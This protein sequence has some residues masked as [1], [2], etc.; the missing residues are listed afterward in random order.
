MSDPTPQLL[1]LLEQGLTP[2][3][4]A[5]STQMSLET[6]ESILG[7]IERKKEQEVKKEFQEMQGL[8]TN[9]IKK[10]LQYGE[11]E[12]AMIRAAELVLDVNMGVKDKQKQTN[13]NIFVLLNERLGAVKQKRRE[14]DD[15]IV[16]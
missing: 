12:S 4:I 3:Q 8:A 5:E 1:A 11:N 9:A 7:E 2:L 6:V 10:V 14:L 13:A 15:A 16:V